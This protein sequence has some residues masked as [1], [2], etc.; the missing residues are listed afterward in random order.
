MSASFLY[1]QTDIPVG[2][3]AATYRQRNA[4]GPSP[5]GQLALTVRA[6]ARYVSSLAANLSHGH[7]S[8]LP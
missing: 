7:G 2:M 6:A 8:A 5:F 4:S 1:E 3:T